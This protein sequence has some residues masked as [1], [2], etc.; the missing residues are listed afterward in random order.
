MN[1][2]LWF[3]IVI[4]VLDLAGRAYR[5]DSGNRTIYTEEIVFNL[6]LNLFVTIWAACLLGAQP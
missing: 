4:G 5:L 2:L 1:T 3:L 6:F